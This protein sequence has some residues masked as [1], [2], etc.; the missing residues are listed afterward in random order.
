[1]KAHAK[2]SDIRPQSEIIK[3]ATRKKLVKLYALPVTAVVLN[4][5]S[6]L[7]R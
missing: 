5:C 6:T 7:F 2:F 3:A 4:K 1:V